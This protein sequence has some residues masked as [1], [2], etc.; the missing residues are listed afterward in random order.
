MS[1]RCEDKVTRTQPSPHIG[2]TKVIYL[3]I[4]R[5]RKRWYISIARDIWCTC[6]VLSVFHGPKMVPKC[7]EHDLPNCRQTSSPRQRSLPAACR[8]SMVLSAPRTILYLIRS[9]HLPAD[10]N[11]FHLRRR[12]MDIMLPFPSN[13][14]LISLS[15]RLN[16][17]VKP[18]QSRQRSC[19][20]PEICKKAKAARIHWYGTPYPPN[21]STHTSS[22]SSESS[23]S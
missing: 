15:S 17:Q 22:L 16:V 5:R 11:C 21:C 2:T 7:P 12:S 9:I 1:T 13:R 18:K 6:S 10:A 8:A 20:D 4:S 3:G 14:V 23:Y 19:P